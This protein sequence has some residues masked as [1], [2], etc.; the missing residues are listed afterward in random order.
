MAPGKW[1]AD[2]PDHT[3]R[4]ICEAH[5]AG[6]FVVEDALDDSI[7][8][9]AGALTE[10]GH[11]TWVFQAASEAASSWKDLRGKFWVVD[12]DDGGIWEWGS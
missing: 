4:G 1:M 2:L 6:E 5:R 10:K 9:S 12:P 7:V 8:R 3:A 11:G